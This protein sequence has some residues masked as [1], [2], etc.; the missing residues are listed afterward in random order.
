MDKKDIKDG[1]VVVDRWSPELGAG[2]I[3]YVRKTVFN[4]DFSGNVI[5]YDYPHSQFL[6]T[7]EEYIKYYIDEAK[8]KYK[9]KKEIIDNAQIILYNRGIGVTKK[10]IREIL[11]KN[12]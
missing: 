12:D 4:V 10:Q 8:R 9:T 7:W 11:N 5:K 3:R 6:D 2:I 1:I